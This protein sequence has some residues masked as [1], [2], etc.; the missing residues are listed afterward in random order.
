MNW[1]RGFRR[2]VFVSA[3]FIAIICAG[4]SVVFILSIHTEAQSDLQWKQKQYVEQCKPIENLPD[5][6]VLDLDAATTSKR[7]AAEE[8]LE[9]LLRKKVQPPSAEKQ[10][11][12]MTKPSAEL[13]EG[14]RTAEDIIEKLPNLT[15]LQSIHLDLSL[16][17][18]SNKAGEYSSTRKKWIEQ[19][20]KD[21]ERKLP[22]LEALQQNKPLTAEQ[23]QSAIETLEHAKSVH[24]KYLSGDY[25]ITSHTGSKKWHTVWI[26]KYNQL[27]E[28][29][30][31]EPWADTALAK[32]GETTTKQAEIVSPQ[33]KRTSEIASR[34][35]SIINAAK[36]DKASGETYAKIGRKY[37][38]ALRELSNEADKID[39]S[40]AGQIDR[41]YNNL[42][43]VIAGTPSGTINDAIEAL[44]RE[45]QVVTKQAEIP[46]KG[47]E[48]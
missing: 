42:S 48:K 47:E 35:L 20:T 11:W 43:D 6:F 7:K 44:N 26:N 30:K 12:E 18:A 17:E 32:S 8:K 45:A 31:G 2:I 28:Y 14:L 38:K 39:R 10:A 22:I 3:I 46:A 23:K 33:K 15:P 19:L 29:V 21:S 5:G 41:I 25:K 1:K 40:F 4:L 16:H 9:S 37:D 36:L 34:V 24:E 27:I 13:P